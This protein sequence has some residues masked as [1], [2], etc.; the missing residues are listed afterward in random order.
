MEAWDPSWIDLY[1]L[2]QS[3]SISSSSSSVISSYGQ[4]ST[5][6]SLPST[7]NAAKE[8]TKEVSNVRN[9][10][11]D[12]SSWTSDN[13]RKSTANFNSNNDNI[14]RSSSPSNATSR[15]KTP[16]SWKSLLATSTSSTQSHGNSKEVRN[17]NRGESNSN[18]SGSTS[19]VTSR[20]RTTVRDRPSILPEVLEDVV[21]EDFNRDGKKI[22]SGRHD[23]K[24]SN[25]HQSST[26][27]DASDVC[28]IEVGSKISIPVASRPVQSFFSWTSS[29]AW[30]SGERYYKKSSRIHMETSS[31]SSEEEIDG[32]GSDDMV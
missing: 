9:I 16:A 3:Q 18:N 1:P 25:D 14:A 15:I 24:P 29:T 5:S 31:Y 26:T 22:S 23:S 8:S 21:A 6:L 13:D 27:M 11:V 32:R 4:P 28:S 20:V 10:I 12:D 30:G 2:L 19:S 17:D 7:V